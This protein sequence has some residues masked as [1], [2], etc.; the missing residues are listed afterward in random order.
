MVNWKEEEK[1]KA[2]TGQWTVLTKPPYSVTPFI[3]FP[4]KL[5]KI[6]NYLDS[7]GER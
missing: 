2:P 4:L 6:Y 7:L 1:N 3:V 5:I